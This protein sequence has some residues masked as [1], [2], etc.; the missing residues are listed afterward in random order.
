MANGILI[1]EDN[2]CVRRI[3]KRALEGE[4]DHEICSEAI[5][6]LD[7]IREV[8]RVHPALVVVDFSMPGLNGLEV[9]KRIKSVSPN[10][11]VILFSMF[12]DRALEN[13]AFQ[14]G[15]SM[16][17]SKEKGIPALAESARLL[18]KYAKDP[19]ADS[20]DA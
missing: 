14:A 1:I 9:T 5:N 10:T 18:L 20:T 17:V 2:T 15:A 6:G 13:Q 11:P 19:M 8:E 3:M 7:G 4:L 16:V 12:T